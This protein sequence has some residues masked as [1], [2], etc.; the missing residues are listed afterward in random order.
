[1][2]TIPEY[3]QKWIETVKKQ[4][5]IIVVSNG[6]DKNIEKFFKEKGIEY[7]GFAGKPLRK[8]FID[9]CNRMNLRPEQVMVI[10]DS[11]FSDIYGGKR[12]NMKTV[13]VKRVDEE[14]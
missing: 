9:A 3:N 5:K 14:R 1:M 13:H 11:L 8:S 2:N 12:N 7:I 6:I 4:L 10:G